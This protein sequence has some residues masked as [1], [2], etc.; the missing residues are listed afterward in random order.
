VVIGKNADADTWL[1]SGVFSFLVALFLAGWA[2]T[3]LIQG[4]RRQRPWIVGPGLPGPFQSATD[5]IQALERHVLAAYTIPAGRL[6]TFQRITGAKQ[7][8]ARHEAQVVAKAATVATPLLVLAAFAIVGATVLGF[9]AAPVGSAAA[10]LVVGLLGAGWAIYAAVSD[11][12]LAKAL[13]NQPRPQCDSEE[14]RRHVPGGGDPFVLRADLEQRLMSLRRGNSPNRLDHSDW[15]GATAHLADTGQFSEYLIWEK[16]PIAVQPIANPASVELLRTTG[17]LFPIAVAT[18]ALTIPGPMLAAQLVVGA[19]LCWASFAQVSWLKMLLNRHAWESHVLYLTAEGS[20]GRAEIVAGRGRDDSF[21]SRNVVIRTDASFHWFS[22]RIV[23]ENADPAGDRIVVESQSDEAARA[24]SDL[25]EEA[26]K[27]FQAVGVRIRSVQLD[28]P[29]V[30]NISR[31]NVAISHARQTPPNPRI[32]GGKPVPTEFFPE[33]V[34]PP[35]T[36]G[37]PKF[38]PS[39]GIPQKHATAR[40]CADCGARIASDG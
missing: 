21:E 20:T 5:P 36:S 11:W 35:P 30:G 16:Q 27:A 32:A 8:F 14:R 18:L 2:L 6:R 4:K 19:V 37:S 40:F 7:V 10:F 33:K 39:C 34:D 24:L 25:T 1:P 3:W 12:K 29:S 28:E 22:A 9:S 31:A 15:K 17:L 38:C 23:S 26:I 13:L